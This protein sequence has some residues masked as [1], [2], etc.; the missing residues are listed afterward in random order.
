MDKEVKKKDPSHDYL[1]AWRAKNQDK[2][3]EL[4][5]LVPSSRVLALNKEATLLAA[6]T[7]AKASSSGASSGNEEKLIIR[8]WPKY[9]SEGKALYNA[10]KTRLM[11]N[12]DIKGTGKKE[13]F[14]SNT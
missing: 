10:A 1:S 2:M 4:S 3:N 12:K 8:N 11:T 14:V 9:I 7:E 13:G 6:A 5:D